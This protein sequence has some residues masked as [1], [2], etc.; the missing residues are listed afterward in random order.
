VRIWHQSFTDLDMVRLYRRT[1]V[2][3]AA[4][5]PIRV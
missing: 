4:A 1:L 2:E 5:V 3:H